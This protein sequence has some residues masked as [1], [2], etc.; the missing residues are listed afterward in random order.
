MLTSFFKRIE[1]SIASFYSLIT[2]RASCD[3]EIRW[4]KR[5]A[6][7]RFYHNYH[8]H[9]CLKIN[10]RKI[11]KFMHP[12]GT[13]AGIRGDQPFLIKKRIKEYTFI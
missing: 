6:L 10:Y 9:F 12:C 11:R 4:K 2:N 13:L 5:H 3:Q 8:A 1:L 7:D